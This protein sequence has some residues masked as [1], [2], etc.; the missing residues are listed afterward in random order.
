MS[1]LN[2]VIAKYNEVKGQEPEAVKG[3]VIDVV[4]S[5]EAG[6]FEVSVVNEVNEVY[7]IKLYTKKYDNGKWIDDAESMDRISK[8]VKDRWNVEL[9]ELE[10]LIEKE[11]PFFI[12]D[13]F[14]ASIFPRRASLFVKFE[15]DDAGF[16]YD[17]Q[18][19]DVVDNGYGIFFYVVDKDNP[20]IDKVWR[21]RRSYS[22]FNPMTKQ[23]LVS[24]ATKIKAYQRLIE[25]FGTQN[26]DEII[27]KDV[28]VKVVNSPQYGIFGQM[29]V[30]KKKQ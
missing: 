24:P 29:K 30:K 25:D 11:V 9:S 1:K 3:I 22:K 14:N 2:E 8:D 27:G 21:L 4:E 26:F 7:E 15:D 13:K 6:V 16:D 12:D 28:E 10:T 19:I 20:S 23:S 5:V 18:V 17:C